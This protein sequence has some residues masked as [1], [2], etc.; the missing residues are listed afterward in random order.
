MP[1]RM[2]PI[3]RIIVAVAQEFNIPPHVIRSRSCVQYAVVARQVAALLTKEMTTMS[4]RAIGI[5]LGDRD[6]TTIMHSASAIVGKMADNPVLALKVERLRHQLLETE[7]QH[8][9]RHEQNS[10][11]AR[12]HGS[13]GSDASTS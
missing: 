11:R 1:V 4:N 5:V 8:E 13:G 3:Q 2:T 10:E 6:H 9:H 7:E 12:D